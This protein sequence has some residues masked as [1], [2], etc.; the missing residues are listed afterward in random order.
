[1]GS[2]IFTTVDEAVVWTLV[3]LP[4]LVRRCMFPSIFTTVGETVYGL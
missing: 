2:C 3:Y 4:Q 1:M